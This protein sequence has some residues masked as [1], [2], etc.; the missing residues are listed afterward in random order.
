M[1]WTLVEPE[2]ET[3]EPDGSVAID[4][5]FDGVVKRF[6]D[7]VAVAGVGFPSDSFYSLLGPSRCGKTT[8]LRLTAGFEQP[9]E[10]RSSSAA[11]RSRVGLRT[12]ATST[13]LGLRVRRSGA[14]SARIST[15]SRP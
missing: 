2:A 3:R 6:D 13:R 4:V 8:S 14:T 1:N 5:R 15:Q 12:G 7:V 9:T 11:A 10:G